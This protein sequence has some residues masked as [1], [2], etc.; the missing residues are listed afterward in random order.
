M[1]SVDLENMSRTAVET[2]VHWL[3][4]YKLVSGRVAKQQST[5]TN[6]YHILRKSKSTTNSHTSGYETLCGS[7]YHSNSLIY[8]AAKAPIDN[9][10]VCQKCMRKK[11]EMLKAK[12]ALGE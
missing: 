5:P 4:N 11:R 6:V 1:R 12:R 8:D 10:R 9:D 2:R 7:A 3:D